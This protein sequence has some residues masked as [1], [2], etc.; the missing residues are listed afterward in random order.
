MAIDLEIRHCRALVAVHDHGGVGAAARAMGVAQSTV[1]ETMLSLERLLDAPVTLR[2]AGREAVLTPSAQ[3]LL[4]HARSLIALS[5]AALLAVARNS[6]ATIRLG[7][8]ESISS[9]LLPGPLSDFRL[10]WPQVEVRIATG[11]C[12]DLRQRVTRSELDVAVTIE[13]AERTGDQT[14]IHEAWPAR[15]RLVV[16]PQHPLAG[17][18]A[19]RVDLAARTYLFADPEGAF[20]DLMKIWAGRFAVMPRFESAGS[21]G[22]VKRGVLK[23]EAI[24]VLPDYAVAEEL[25][26]GSLAALDTEEPLPQIALRLTLANSPVPASPL[27][28]LIGQIRKELGY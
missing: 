2:R 28:S 15:L 14:A 7:T 4:P 21:V 13:G 25:A 6:Q 23:S 11:L 12:A 9:F 22:G 17:R 18:T 3:A 27:E 1:S 24:G 8:V 20:H 19:S 10:M 26:M 16:G 5:Q